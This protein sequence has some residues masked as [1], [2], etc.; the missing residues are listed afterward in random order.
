[1][2]AGGMAGRGAG[3]ACRCDGFRTHA[4]RPNRASAASPAPRPTASPA[5]AAACAPA[6]SADTPSESRS[7]G[8]ASASA[9]SAAPAAPAAL[10]ARGAHVGSPTRAPRPGQVPRGSSRRARTVVCARTDVS[11]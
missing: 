5:P 10:V 1:V 2:A 7:H 11:A 9:A 8:P 4:N 3:A 6:L